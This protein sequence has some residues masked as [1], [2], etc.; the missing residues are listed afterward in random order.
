[1]MGP[2]EVVCVGT[3]RIGIV[4]PPWFAVPPVGYGGVEWVVSYL[5]DGLVERGHDV[6]LFASGGSRTKARLVTVYDDPPSAALGDGIVEAAHVAHAYAL[7]RSFD[8]IHDHTILGLLA[9]RSC[10]VPVVHTVHGEVTPLVARV[11]RELAPALHFVAISNNQAAT[12]PPGCRH[13][14]VY[15]GIDTSLFPFRAQPG[16]YLLFVGRM[17][18]EKGI[19]PA[20]EIARRTGRPLLVLAKVNEAPEKEFFE[21]MVRPALR[22]VDAEVRLQVTHEEKA[23]AYGEAYATLFPIGW[24]EPF[25][26]VMVESMAAGTPVI[27]FRN[28][29]VPE[30][31]KDGVTGFVCETVEEAVA[32]VGRVDEIDRGACRRH[33]EEHF[34][35]RVNV[36]QHE[37]LFLS[38]AGETRPTNRSLGVLAALQPAGGA[39]LPA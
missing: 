19:L 39:P 34:S 33:V 6:T 37:R 4:A 17:N 28:G 5:A 21:A 35:A 15:N 29:S 36:E 25:G 16:E 22:G 2:R 32:A 9:A 30:V 14:T 11:Y 13:T 23:R 1:M 10:A 7:E 27:A 12:L 24:P 26:L 31:V 3:L 8:I 18:A 20:I 38:L